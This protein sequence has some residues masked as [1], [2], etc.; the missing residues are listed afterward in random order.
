MEGTVPFRWAT[1]DLILENVC[2]V[3]RGERQMYS[4]IPPELCHDACQYKR[5]IF[6]LGK[7]NFVIK[8]IIYKTV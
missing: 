4:V 6:V 7:L 8:L 1:K 2:L 5:Y 3:V